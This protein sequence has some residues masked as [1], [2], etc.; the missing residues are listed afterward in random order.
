[1]G[2]ELPPVYAMP[3]AITEAGIEYRFLSGG[4]SLVVEVTRSWTAG[5]FIE[6]LDGGQHVTGETTALY[7]EARSLLTAL[8]AESP[9]G[10]ITYELRTTYPK[11][12]AWAEGPGDEL[13]RWESVGWRDDDGNMVFRTT[14]RPVDG[15]S[16]R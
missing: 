16:H 7:G 2:K 13:F 12:L 1:M 14:V 4:K 3:P 5:S 6:N 15:Q 9:I 11:M 8:A 10:G